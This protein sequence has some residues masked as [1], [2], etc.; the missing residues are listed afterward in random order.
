VTLVING[1]DGSTEQM[2]QEQIIQVYPNAQAA[3]TVTPNE[4]SIPSQPVY[5]LNL[6]S[7]A[8]SYEWDF[9]DG[10][11]SNDQ[12]PI[13]YFTEEG[14]FSITLI[15]NN[16]Y[17]CPDTMQLVDAVYA[18]K[19][20]LIDFPNAFTPDPNGGAGGS[21]NPNSYDN[22]VFFPIH[23]GVT[24]YQ[25]LIY[26]KWGELLYESN[27][28]NRG[29]DG[30]YRGQLCKQDVYVWKVNARFVD[31]QKFEKAGDVTLLVK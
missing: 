12:N 22:D 24:E 25:L 31:G 2:V 19:G 4:I 16:E 20:G 1:F 28:V 9:G 3:F 13:H 6:S 7:N 8:N 5:C 29:W 10:N 21:Y 17:N 26:N 11:F 30:F 18:K 23:S 14:I 27:D 15:A